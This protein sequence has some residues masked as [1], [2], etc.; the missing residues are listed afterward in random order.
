[1]AN[2]LVYFGSGFAFYALDAGAGAAV[3]QFVSLGGTEYSSPTAAEG[4]VFFFLFWA[5][6]STR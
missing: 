2:G 3:W 1:M 4:K 6:G 5:P